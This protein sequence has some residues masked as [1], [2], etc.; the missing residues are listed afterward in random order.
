MAAF[1]SFFS[2][3]ITSIG[4]NNAG[5][6]TSTKIARPECCLLNVPD[7]VSFT[8]RFF[9]A[10]MLDI[11]MKVVI[12]ANVFVSGV[13]FTG[14]PYKILEAWKDG[15]IQ[16]VT[17]PVIL[18]EYPEVALKLSEQYQ[19]IT[20]MKPVFKLDVSPPLRSAPEIGSRKRCYRATIKGQSWGSP[21]LTSSLPLPL[22]SWPSSKTL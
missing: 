13:F 5:L 6:S 22:W 16:L 18:A 8:H 11:G 17:S 21:L 14:P 15:R 4:Q 3:T 7:T 1:L 20:K 10:V 9:K 2:S 12:D 19:D